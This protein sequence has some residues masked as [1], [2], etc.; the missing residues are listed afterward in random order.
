III[1]AHRQGV[2]FYGAAGNAPVDTPYYPAAY[3]EVTAVTAGDRNRNIA[4]FA[5]HGEFV[6]MVAPGA[7][8]IHFA[9]RQ[10]VV[11]GT[12]ASAAFASGFAAGMADSRRTSPKEVDKL[13]RTN[14]APNKKP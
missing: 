4:P 6:D 11:G 3:P 7:S 13:M 12:S 5:N 14:F 2:V 1:E 10:F 8:V 9:G